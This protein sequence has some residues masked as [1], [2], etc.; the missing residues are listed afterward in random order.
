MG[1]RKLGAVAMCAASN[2]H[3]LYEI[4]STK[5][6][7]LRAVNLPCGHK[8]DK[9]IISA[10]HIRGGDEATRMLDYL[11]SH[12]F[13]KAEAFEHIEGLGGKLDDGLNCRVPEE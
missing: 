3:D 12:D 10:T 4:S 8:I 9:L 1:F 13:I 11:L 5:L 2:C 6:G 7:K